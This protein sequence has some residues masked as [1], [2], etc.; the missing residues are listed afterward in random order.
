M[1]CCSGVFLHIRDD[2]SYSATFIGLDN[3]ELPLHSGSSN[4]FCLWTLYNPPSTTHLVLKQ[5]FIYVKR[6]ITLVR[7]CY[8]DVKVLDSSS[9]LYKISAGYFVELQSDIG[10]ARTNFNDIM[11]NH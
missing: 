11:W 9:A 1:A 6:Y 7:I 3:M 5:L 8:F 2:L 10:F 4:C